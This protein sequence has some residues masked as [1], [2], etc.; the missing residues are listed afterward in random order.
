[1]EQPRKAARADGV[2]DVQG[3]LM[4][5]IASGGK[6][7]LDLSKIE[8]VDRL[9]HYEYFAD[10]DSKYTLGQE[11]LAANIRYDGKPITI[12]K[13]VGSGTYGMV[14]LAQVTGGPKFVIKVQEIDEDAE[15]GMKTAEALR[16][17]DLV[18]FRAVEVSTDTT[19][20]YLTFM[21]PLDG[22]CTP[23]VMGGL[24]LTDGSDA[25]EKNRNSFVQFMNTLRAC[26]RHRGA[27]YNDMK[28][29]NI[30]YKR[31]GNT[32]QFSLID[33]DGIS[34]RVSTYPAIERFVGSSED[35]YARKSDDRVREFNLQTDYAFAVT[36]L[37][38]CS[39]DAS[40]NDYLS[41][42]A[43]NYDARKDYLD[44]VMQR[45]SESN[46]LAS[47]AAKVALETIRKCEALLY[48]PPTYDAL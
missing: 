48:Q 15:F 12:P 46:K 19:S 37:I 9:V 36:K 33:L 40:I 4:V 34:D 28:P 30:G 29:G 44:M 26:L 32:Y 13:M 2:Y 16:E 8:V 31:R 1:M 45:T 11:T 43:M 14:H 27:T 42:G 20:F 17:C 22:D 6:S 10:G 41:Y 3:T 47:E 18:S 25:D 24:T 39:N 21:D 5:G 35:D 7:I 23:G 38:V